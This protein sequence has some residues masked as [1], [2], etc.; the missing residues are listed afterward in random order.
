MK[1]VNEGMKWTKYMAMSVFLIASFTLASCGGQNGVK[2]EYSEETAVVS[3]QT[4]E[5]EYVSSGIPMTR[6]YIIEH[7]ILTEEELVGVD[8]D[9]MIAVYGLEEGDE[10]RTDIRRF[11]LMIKDDYPL[12]GYGF[13]YQY[14]TEGERSSEKLTNEDLANIKIISWRYNSETYHASLLFDFTE[15]KA[16]FGELIDLLER[17]AEPTEEIDLSDEQMEAIE[18][19]F[20][21]NHVEKWKAEYRD[22]LS[23]TKC[24][25]YWWR[26]VIELE[27]GR[28]YKYS[29]DDVPNN[30]DSITDALKAYFGYIPY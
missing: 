20:Q 4:G 9:D 15:K 8:I 13:N 22:P 17:A 16:Y 28:I 25:G 10:E 2:G 18:S 30:Y 29:G 6:E 5:N 23:W 21:E 24:D 11:I 12:P 26:M 19:L 27:D 1:G 3:T 7:G 14:L